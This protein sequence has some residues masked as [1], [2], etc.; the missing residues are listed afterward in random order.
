MDGWA[1]MSLEKPL[2]RETDFN[3]TNKE[4]SI[5]VGTTRECLVMGKWRH[6]A[7]VSRPED[8]EEPARHRQK[9]SSSCYSIILNIKLNLF[10]QAPAS[11]HGSYG[12]FPF[13]TTC[14]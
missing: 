3:W 12:T 11:H 13:N 10:P 7:E 4:K 8:P 6:H 1:K 5:E 9:T 14:S 2:S